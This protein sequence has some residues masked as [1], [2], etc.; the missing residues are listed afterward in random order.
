MYHQIVHS[1]SFKQIL[2][3]TYSKKNR[4]RITQPG[5]SHCGFRKFQPSYQQDYVDSTVLTRFNPRTGNRYEPWIIC[6]WATDW[7]WRHLNEFVWMLK[8]LCESGCMTSVWRF[9]VSEFELSWFLFI[10]ICIKYNTESFSL[11]VQLSCIFPLF[12]FHWIVRRF[13][14]DSLDLEPGRHFSWAIKKETVFLE[15]RFQTA[16][17]SLSD[18]LFFLKENITHKN[19]FAVSFLHHRYISTA[20]FSRGRG[21]DRKSSCS[22]QTSG[23]DRWHLLDKSLTLHLYRIEVVLMPF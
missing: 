3:F 20:G 7:K 13:S 16:G 11:S 21:Y 14:L 2:W 5:C 12:V 17:C 19:V 10:I 6:Y 18:L 22:Q 4:D 8:S 15:P 23:D 9:L 1:S